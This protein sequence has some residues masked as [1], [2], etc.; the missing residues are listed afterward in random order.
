MQTWAHNQSEWAAVNGWLQ[1]VTFDHVVELWWKA[2]M[3]AADKAERDNARRA[4]PGDMFG[5][6]PEYVAAY[7]ATKRQ[8][9]VAV[10]EG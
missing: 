2:Q 3:L 5:K 4:D 10:S 9:P 7:Y 6:S 1:G 8:A